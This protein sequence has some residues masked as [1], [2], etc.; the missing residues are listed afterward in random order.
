MSDFTAWPAVYRALPEMDIV[1][2]AYRLVP[3]RYADREAIRQWRNAQLDVL[4]QP[5]PISGEEQDQYFLRVVRPL[6]DQVQPGQLLFSL[7]YEGQLI[8]YGGLVYI[9]WE[10]RRAEVSFLVDSARVADLPLYRQDFLTYLHLLGKLAFGP[11]GLHRLF[12]ECYDIRDFHVSILEEAG[13][14]FE[15]RLRHHVRIRGRFVDSLIH[16]LLAEDEAAVG[17]RPSTTLEQSIP[18]LIDFERRRTATGARSD[19]PG[20]ILITSLARKVPLAQAVR[21]A[22]QKRHPGIRII[23]ADANPQCVGRQFTDGFWLMPATSDEN[24]AQILAYCQENNVRYVIPTRD[25]ELAFW[26]RHR[27]TLAAQGI[28]VLVSAPASLERCLDKL[29]FAEFG[30]Q[31]DLPFIPAALAAAN[32]A[33]D[34]F[35]VK[36]RRGAGSRQLGLNLPL[37]AALSHAATLQEPIFQP[38]VEGRE[39]SVDAYVN[40]E[41]GV[42]GL[43]LRTRD[44]VLQGESQ[45]TTTFEDAAL[46]ERLAAI[47]GQLGLYGPVVLQALIDEQNQLHVIECNCRFGGASSL[48][49]A[50]GL[51]TFYWFLLEAAGQDLMAVPF[52]P[53]AGNLRQI[54]YPADV[55]MVVE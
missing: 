28:V 3:I 46:A 30:Q 8:G 22:A 13:F 36:E 45:I 52:V 47:I 21:A 44:V 24:L 1:R 19:A 31:H 51:D 39:I 14:R 17:W 50:K 33:A 27:E 54:R 41:G 29:L 4:R 48:A 34:T 7:L 43:V 10:D 12:T 37:A 42:Q 6:F 9:A 2:G 11:L 5:A 35:V 25:G 53:V 40:R 15:G 32:I 23:G 18:Q 49:V 16:S 38:F 55:V 26:S 20:H